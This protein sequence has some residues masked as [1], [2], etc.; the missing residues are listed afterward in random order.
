MQ[1]KTECNDE[2]HLKSRQK[3]APMNNAYRSNAYMNLVEILI[4]Y[5]LNVTYESIYEC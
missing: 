2:F 1:K 5:M 3:T 4:L